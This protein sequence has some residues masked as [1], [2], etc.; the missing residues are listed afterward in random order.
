MFS[1]KKLSLS[2]ST[3][4]QLTPAEMSMVGG[5]SARCPDD[6]F[7]GPCTGSCPTWVGCQSN[8]SVCLCSGYAGC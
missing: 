5:A 6:P 8:E 3:L 4:K 2:K 7:T 1:G